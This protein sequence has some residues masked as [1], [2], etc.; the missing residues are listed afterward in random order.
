MRMGIAV[1][2][3]LARYLEKVHR[4]LDAAIVHPAIDPAMK[5]A[6]AARLAE[7]RARGGDPERDRAFS[8]YVLLRAQ[9]VPIDAQ[10][11]RLGVFASLV[12]LATEPIEAPGEAAAAHGLLAV[13]LETLHDLASREARSDRRAAYLAA[14]RRSAFLQPPEGDADR[15]SPETVLERHRVRRGAAALA[16]ECAAIAAGADDETVVRYRLA[17]EHMACLAGVLEDLADPLGVRL[18]AG[19]TRYPVAAFLDMA[20]GHAREQFEALLDQLP[21]SQDQLE[22]FLSYSGAIMR[23]AEAAERLRAA[24]H[25]ELAAID[26]QSP[27]HRR[28]AQAIDALAARAYEPPPLPAGQTPAPPAGPFRRRL[29]S[30]ARAFEAAMAPFDPPPPP[31][32]LAW[33]RPEWAYDAARNVLGHPDLDGLEA[34]I[35]PGLADS[36]GLGPDA[37]RTLAEALSPLLLAEARFRHWRAAVGATSDDPWQEAAAVSRLTAA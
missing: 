5:Q 23:T 27:H 19:G 7:D 26:P 36:L 15:P 35:L 33:A 25:A 2:M 9:G 10:A 31:P 8:V 30:F 29:E 18:A 3:D 6:L 28:W 32:L 17:G 4:R 22:S 21:A 1:T 11:E 37:A 20:E 14:F 13:A 12:T 34:E 16:V 24:F